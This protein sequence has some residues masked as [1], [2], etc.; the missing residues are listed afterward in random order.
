MPTADELWGQVLEYLTDENKTFVLPKMAFISLES[1]NGGVRELVRS[2]DNVAARMAF[3]AAYERV[4]QGFNGKVEYAVS[5]GT[6]KQNQ[7]D[8]IKTA[9]LKKKI[10]KEIATMFLPEIDEM[11][12]LL[13]PHNPE[14]IEK[15]NKFIAGLID[16]KTD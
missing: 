13:P 3:K 12:G 7:A 10:T 8:T 2:G 5:L 11:L 4:S 14:N 9:Y 16:K 6:D 1:T 15:I